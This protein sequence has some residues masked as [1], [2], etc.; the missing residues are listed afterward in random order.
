MILPASIGVALWLAP[1]LPEPPASLDVGV[2]P[3]AVQDVTSGTL[4][5]AD[6]DAADEDERPAEDTSVVPS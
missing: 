1:T 4:L 5:T 3:A 2:D 6:A